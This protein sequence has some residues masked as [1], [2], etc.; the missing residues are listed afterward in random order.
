MDGCMDGFGPDRQV[1]RSLDL[2]VVFESCELGEQVTIGCVGHS[3]TPD[4][5]EHLAH[6]ATNVV[7]RIQ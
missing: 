6:E 5:K 4:A 3:F 2:R 1:L 7:E